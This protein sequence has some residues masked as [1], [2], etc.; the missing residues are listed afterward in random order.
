VWKGS[1]LS[2]FPPWFAINRIGLVA[3]WLARLVYL[4]CALVYERYEWH[5]GRR[6]LEC[7]QGS[8][9]S[10]FSIVSVS[11]LLNLVLCF[12]NP[13][14]FCLLNDWLAVRVW[15]SQSMV[16]ADVKKR[17]AGA[18]QDKQVNFFSR[19]SL[20]I[21]TCL[22]SLVK[23]TTYLRYKA[24]LLLSSYHISSSLSHPWFKK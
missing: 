5:L 13:I 4:G 15:F 16:Y 21:F 20:F 22:T 12:R 1:N 9:F 18:V 6:I 8:N 14:L 17:I 2:L 19:F 24:T 11:L 10:I 23:W 3:Q 7:Y